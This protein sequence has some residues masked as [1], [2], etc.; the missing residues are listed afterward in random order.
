MS[1]PLKILI[2]RTSSIGD[3]VQTLPVIDYLRARFPHAIIDWVVEKSIAPLLAAHPIDKVIPIESK[4]WRSLS[5]QLSSLRVL[6]S[7]QYDLVFDLQGNI[8][9]GIVTL[10]ARAKSKVGF[11]WDSVRERPNVLATHYRFNFPHNLNVREKYLQ[12]VQTYLEAHPIQVVAT[13]VDPSVAVSSL[14]DQE[15]SRLSKLIDSSQMKQPFVLMIAIG[16]RWKNKMIHEALLIELLRS[17]P[18]IEKVG[19]FI[20]FSNEEEERIGQSIKKA[21]DDQGEVVGHLSLPLW[22]ALMKE[23]DGVIAVDSAALHL[24][25]AVGTPVFSF[26][27]PT[28]AEVFAPF[29]SQNKVYQGVCPYGVVFDKQCPQLRT[30]ESGACLKSLCSEDVIDAFRSWL[31]IRKIEGAVSEECFL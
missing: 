2:V 17:I 6:R 20:V 8:K 9:S 10:L 26:F 13:E 25:G 5:T 14:T 1:V 18:Q 29:G 4:K 3:V 23:M 28:R 16:S 7:R 11:G 15:L 21:L 19:F 30:C 24:A 12:L 27:G 22:Q 31:S